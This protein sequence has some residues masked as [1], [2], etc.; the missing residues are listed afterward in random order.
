MSGR[1]LRGVFMRRVLKMAGG[2]ALASGALFAA[3][4]TGPKDE[5]VEFNRDVRPILSD[6][7]FKCHGFDKNARKADLRLDLRE[8]A[9]A[10]RKKGAP[11]V[12]GDPDHSE[13]FRRL[14]AKD[15]EDLMPPAKSNLKLTTAQIETLR[16]WIAQG[17]EYQPHWAFIA[18]VEPAMPVVKKKEWPRNPID[19]FILAAL[20]AQNL[21]PSPEAEKATLIRRVMLD[22]T[23]LPP[24]PEEVDTFLADTSPQAYENL[25]DRLLKSPRYGERMAWDWLEAARYSD[26]NG[27]QA[28]PERTMW[29]WRDWVVKSLNENLPYDRFT[30]E[31]L[32]GDLLPNATVE[33]RLATGFNRNHMYNG[34]G[35]RIPEETRAENVMD[36][37]ET[38]ATVWLGATFTCCRCHDHK[39]DPYTNRDYYGLYA[40]FNQC[41]EEGG[42]YG[43]GK[44][45]PIVEV[46]TP[47][48]QAKHD[49]FAA[50]VKA[51]EDAVAAAGASLDGEQKE[52]EKGAAQGP[53][54]ETPEPTGA[55]SQSGAAL[56]KQP[57][58]SLLA[59]TGTAQQDVYTVTLRTDK[60]VL[61]GLRL[62]TL[63]HDSL[64]GGGPGLRG[65]GNFILTGL[66]VEAI[67]VADPLQIVKVKL[68]GARADYEQQGWPVAA[69]LD[70]NKETG[71]AV[72]G[73]TK[74]EQR[75]AW[76]AF[77]QPAGFAGGTDL[78]V[79]LRCEST[80][81]PDHV[82]GRPRVSVTTA[83]APLAA[84]L[85]PELAAILALPE[86]QRND[87]QKKQ[88]GDFFRNTVSTKLKP[89]NDAVAAAKKQRDDF[90]NTLPKVMVMDDAKPRQTH[91]LVRGSYDKPA[92][93]VD[94]ATPASLP[95]LP[96][97]APRNR[98]SLARWLVDGK[99]PLT[100]RVTVNRV[101]QAFFGVGLVKTAEDFGLQG[102]NPKNPPLMDYLAV[103]FAKDW[104][105]KGLQRLIVTSATYR[106]SSKATPQLRERD[107]EN[108]LL[109]RGPRY[110]MP[111]WML[112]DQALLV[113]G[114]LVE[115]MG[116]PS[117]NTYQPAGIWEEATF[118][119]K[120]YVQDHGE[121]LY[122]RSL[123]IFWRRIVGPTMFFDVAAR[124]TC[125]VNF[126][127]T[128]TPLQAL[129]TLNETTYVEAARAMAQRLLESPGDDA[130]HAAR[131]FR[132][133]VCRP[134]RP[135][136]LA[137]LTSSLGQFRRRYEAD[138]EAAA[139]L[140]KTG[141]SPRDEKLD[142]AEHAAW[143]SLCLMI[144]NLDETMSK[145]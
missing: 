92:D 81:H 103:R 105:V 33:Q 11:I 51:A 37:V 7:C 73:H 119:S 132:L 93:K 126:S 86:A 102:E 46:T 76:F 111:S 25:V 145:Q 100:A 95:P 142:A 3:A 137:V 78:R 98:L 23:G 13:V 79:T 17:A 39:Y 21:S 15:P 144:L 120:K 112:R 85:A 9:V 70:D 124:Q 30:I 136:E 99:H 68:A 48:S 87:G 34:E 2:L 63:K 90:G 61:T 26:S 104:D 54:W 96:E 42:T 53:Q 72:D 67:S 94:P 8:E 74:R 84:S 125:A 108:R 31:Q 50:A 101:W 16:R 36:R 6:T 75:A 55:M 113:S 122:R 52:W 40:M 43:N 80:Q 89:L 32:G 77:A 29:P 82:V 133:A 88:L 121:S 62:E 123:Y 65:N 115:K 22:L 141:E 116:G 59:G 106:Q 56:T 110:R 14:I 38:T 41:S 10:K 64:F 24:T 1:F 4:P 44:I 114:L 117:V 69:V 66:D 19:A 27:F 47:E 129:V 139:K 71:W 131:A 128:N 135:E 28:D 35:G 130:A 5:K 12:P 18:P 107:P 91:V 58:G 118:G 140:L 109:A 138:K 134:P 60:A 20:E 97:G 49:Q 143:T 127:V 57:D 45:P 83:A